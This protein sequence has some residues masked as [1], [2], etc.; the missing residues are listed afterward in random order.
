MLLII[1][2]IFILIYIS[3]NWD[4]KEEVTNQNEGCR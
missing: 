4:K 2:Y 1:Y 3:M